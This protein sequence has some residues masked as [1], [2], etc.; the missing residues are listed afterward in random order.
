MRK[1]LLLTLISEIKYPQLHAT[2]AAAA[3]A[4][5]TAGV[6]VVQSSL[7]FLMNCHIYNNLIIRTQRRVLYLKWT[8]RTLNLE[9]EKILLYFCYLFSSYLFIFLGAHF[10][11]YYYHY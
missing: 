1:R 10:Y 3:A 6:V 7:G 4:A 9:A 8:K 2:V 5:V 11:H